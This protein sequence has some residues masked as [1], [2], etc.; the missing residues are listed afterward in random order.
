MGGAGGNLGGTLAAV[1]KGAPVVSPRPEVSRPKAVLIR[2]GWPG[3]LVGGTP[4]AGSVP[5]PP[6]A[7]VPAAG[8]PAGEEGGAWVSSG[9]RRVPGWWC[10]S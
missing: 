4:E 1:G 3:G 5:R 10:G 7:A 6:G 2:G 8:R 9:W